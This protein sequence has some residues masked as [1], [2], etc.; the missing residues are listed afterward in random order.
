MTLDELKSNL[1]AVNIYY[2][3]LKYTEFNELPEYDFWDFISNI[4]GFQII[5]LFIINLLFYL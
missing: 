2:P 5:F 3:E 4:G 1:L